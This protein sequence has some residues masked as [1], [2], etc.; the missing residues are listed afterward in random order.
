MW[1]QRLTRGSKKVVYSHPGKASQRGYSEPS[2]GRPLLIGADC[3]GTWTSH[4][5]HGTSPGQK[6]QSLAQ[7]IFWL[8]LN[9]NYLITH[10]VD[11]TI[12]RK[13]QYL[14]QYF[15]CDLRH[16]EWSSGFS[17]EQ[18]F[19]NLLA[20]CNCLPWSNPMQLCII[21]TWEHTKYMLYYEA[22]NKAINKVFE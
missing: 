2:Q 14:I 17:H 16:S 4:N 8:I 5:P 6:P 7:S 19:G 3:K 20:T 18:R 21:S 22:E 1:W 10:T 15:Q 13:V 9:Q 12:W 11:I